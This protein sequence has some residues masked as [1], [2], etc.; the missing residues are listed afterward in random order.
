MTEK[1]NQAKQLDS[2]TDRVEEDQMDS[3]RAMSSLGAMSSHL[4]AGG[5]AADKALAVRPADVQVLCDE[6]DVTEDV[7]AQT[8]RRVAA[9]QPGLST[10]ADA[11]AWVAA[12]L[13]FLIRAP[14]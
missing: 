12:A 13:T 4:G 6:L 7:A 5:A 1:E 2:V 11:E 8:L 9:A 3:S 10:D 14:P